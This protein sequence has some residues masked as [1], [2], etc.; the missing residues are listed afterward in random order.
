MVEWGSTIGDVVKVVN[1]G[2]SAQS[3]LFG[4]VITVWVATINI[5]NLRPITYY[6]YILYSF[7]ALSVTLINFYVKE[8]NINSN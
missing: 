8:L 7:S 2:L 6:F 4:G 5:V 3:V 1:I